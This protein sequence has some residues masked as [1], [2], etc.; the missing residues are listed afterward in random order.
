MLLN[1][2]LISLGL[3]SVIALLSGIVAFF[4]NRKRK[5]NQAW[6]RLNIFTSVWSLGY[7]FM[8]SAESESVAWVSNYVLHGAAIFI[9]T[10]YLH[11]IISLIDRYK[12]YK[13]YLYISYVLSLIFTIFNPTHYFVDD[14]LPKYIF[15]FV[16]NAGPLYIYF[17][18]H[19][20][21]AVAFSL[22]ILY[23]EMLQKTG[24]AYSQLRYVFLSSLLGFSGGGSVFFITFNVQVPPYPVIL[25]ALYPI[26]ITYAI[27]KYRLM[28]VRTVVFRSFIFSLSLAIVTLVFTLLSSLFGLA[29]S[30][31]SNSFL[32]PNIAS[33]LVSGI[34]VVIGYAPLR[35]YFEKITSSFL[36]KQSYNPD[37]LLNSVNDK[38]SRII[39]LDTLLNSVCNLVEES[40]HPTKSAVVL[41]SVDSELQVKYSSGFRKGEPELL[42]RGKESDMLKEFSVSDNHILAID[43]R[44][45]MYEAGEYQPHNKELLYALHSAD[46]SLIIPLTVKDKIIGVIALG[47]KKSGDLY[48]QQDLNVLEL[49]AGQVAIAVENAQLYEEL[50]EFNR[51]LQ[52]RVDDATKELRAANEQLREMDRMKSDFISIASHQLRTPLTVIKGYI[53]MLQEGSFGKVSKKVVTQLDKVFQANERLI[54]LVE[55]LLDISRIESG[56]QEYNFEL[57]QLEDKAAEVVENLKVN[58][59]KKGLKL[60]FKKP[61]KKLPQVMTDRKLHEVMM[62]FVDNAIKYTNEGSIEVTIDNEPEGMVTFSVKDTGTGV[63][64]ETLPH[65]FR[66]FS[67][68]KGSFQ[69]HTEGLGLGLFVAKMIADAHGG[70]LGAESA[71]KGK[72]SRF[73]VSL[74]VTPPKKLPS[75]EEHDPQLTYLGD[76]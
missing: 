36:Y 62:N 52:K 61:K 46:I 66:K 63:D 65:L 18:L 3:G 10:L 12:K 39:D 22:F 51:T 40:F 41:L 16:C 19:F 49:I 55:N 2:F 72:G 5:M 9:P 53:S 38:T 44:K 14:V 69:M 23:R 75:E 71:G 4:R 29:F 34:L 26:V 68:A 58:A 32:S 56:R 57:T 27:V 73:F 60:T 20:F 70:T 59:D 30:S 54:D 35:K 28:D 43:E 11:F 50:K 64:K 42:A 17:T 33:G 6:L 67:R 31:G 47:T 25:F 7:F 1:Y 21:G 24:A 37:K 48:T 45:A 8:I 74:P 13:A 15:N 76:E